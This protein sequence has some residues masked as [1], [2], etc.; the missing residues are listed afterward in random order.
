MKKANK[1]NTQIHDV[2][3]KFKKIQLERNYEIS[4]Q[5][6]YI[7]KQ[8]NQLISKNEVNSSQQAHLKHWIDE[9]EKTNKKQKVTKYLTLLICIKCLYIYILVS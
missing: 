9:S 4:A 3:N 6:E 2:Q 8:N 5:N 1:L 7:R